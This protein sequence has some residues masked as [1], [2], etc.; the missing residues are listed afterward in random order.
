MHLHLRIV[1]VTKL[2]VFI[3][4]AA[5]VLTALVRYH[6]A[7]PAPS[8]INGVYRNPCYSPIEI[9]GHSLAYRDTHTRVDIAMMKFGL[10]GY[11][12]DP[13]GP[14]YTVDAGG[15]HPPVLSFDVLGQFFIRDS[16]G[17]GHVFIR[18]T[19]QDHSDRTRC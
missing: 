1:T 13:V 17:R 11:V 10:R 18:S 7:A 12:K 6:H 8:E 15:A 14:F 4:G 2:I 9:N 5:V 3:I 19:Q 16:D